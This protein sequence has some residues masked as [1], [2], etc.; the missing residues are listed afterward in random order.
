MREA[1]DLPHTMLAFS[2]LAKQQQELHSTGADKYAF[3]Y[4]VNDGDM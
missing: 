3:L 4:S 1:K 2:A